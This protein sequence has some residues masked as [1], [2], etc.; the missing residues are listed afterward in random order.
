MS[1]TDFKE[2]VDPPDHRK[3]HPPKIAPFAPYSMTWPDHPTSRFVFEV[4]LVARSYPVSA[5]M[6]TSVH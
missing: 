4:L 1:N 2:G 3:Y 6:P 5:S